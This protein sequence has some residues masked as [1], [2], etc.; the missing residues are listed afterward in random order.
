MY[1]NICRERHS[2]AK[3][4]IGKESKTVYH[5]SLLHGITCQRQ[6]YSHPH[7]SSVP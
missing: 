6:L 1:G 4:N 3:Q 7:P 2:G 5:H